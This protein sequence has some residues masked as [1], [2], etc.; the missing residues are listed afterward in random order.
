M[1]TL[2]QAMNFLAD[3]AVGTTY[4]SVPN[5]SLGTGYTMGTNNLQVAQSAD[6]NTIIISGYIAIDIAAGAAARTVTINLPVTIANP[7]SSAKSFW[8]GFWDSFTWDA[9]TG[10]INQRTAV[11]LNV[12]TNG[13]VTLTLNLSN[14]SGKKTRAFYQQNGSVYRLGG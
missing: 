7:P 10:S 13:S 14:N 5:P 9:V 3:I 11:K 2:D 12:A 4:T 8:T 1:S 6:G